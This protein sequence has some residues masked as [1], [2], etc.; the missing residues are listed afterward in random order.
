MKKYAIIVAGGNGKRMDSNVPKQF[1]LLAGV[2][3]LMRTIRCFYDCDSS[4]SIV[5]VIPDNQRAFWKNSCEK[6]SF[7]IPHDVVSG[8]DTRFLSVKNG[9]DSVNEKS[10]VAVHDGAR[11]FVTNNLINR[12]FIEAEKFGNAVPAVSINESIRMVEGNNSEM[13][14]RE[15]FVLIQTPQ[16]FDSEILKSAY[17]VDDQSV[18][19]DDASVVE[20][21][22]KMIHLIKGE[23]ENIKIT[24][25]V[26]LV[27][28]EAILKAFHSFR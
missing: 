1:M 27:I 22:G 4:I 23:R 20:H 15:K 14:E 19:T 8:G 16:C 7:R 17:R 9:L 5:V 12:C 26:D 11:P 28:G 13:A 21:S 6:Y 10:L 18:F 3:V 24:Y 2:P 25:A